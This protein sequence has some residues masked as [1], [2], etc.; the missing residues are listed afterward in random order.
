MSDFTRRQIAEILEIEESFVIELERESIIQV[1]EGQS[2]YTERMLERARVAHSLVYELE[3]NLAGAAV[4]VRM[5][6]ELGTLRGTLRAL[7]AQLGQP[8]KHD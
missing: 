4:I 1:I 7:A 5:R 6:E 2:V 3:V 8:P